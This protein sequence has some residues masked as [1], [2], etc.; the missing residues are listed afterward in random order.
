M[1]AFKIKRTILL[2]VFHEMKA[3]YRE[4]GPVSF[5]ISRKV[6]FAGLKIEGILAITSLKIILEAFFTYLF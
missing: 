2:E 1:V 3:E 4:N 5:I 6:S